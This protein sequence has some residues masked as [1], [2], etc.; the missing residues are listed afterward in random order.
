MSY[1]ENDKPI[2]DLIAKVFLTPNLCP[3]NSTSIEVMLDKAH[4]RPL[5]E[6]QIE[7]M[8]KKAKSEE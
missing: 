7:R 4:G 1:D 2:R 5:G 3:A 8:L 6:D